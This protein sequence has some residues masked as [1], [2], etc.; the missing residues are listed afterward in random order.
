MNDVP[1][2]RS[3]TQTH[4]YKWALVGLLWFCGF[5]N[6][7]DR[8]AVFSVTRSLQSEFELSKAQL[9]MIGSSF[10]FVYALAAPFAGALVDRG[11]RRAW[12]IGG[13]AFWSLICALTATSQVYWHLLLFRALEGL[14]ETFYFPASMSLIAAFHAPNTR[15]K[16]MGMHQTSVYLGSA[17]GGSIAGVLGDWLGWRS[18][19]WLFG[20][21]GCLLVPMLWFGLRDPEE[22]KKGVVE[23]DDAIGPGPERIGLVGAVLEIVSRPAALGVLG[24]FA[25]ANFV[26]MVLLSWLPYFVSERFG[27]GQARAAFVATLFLQITS[28]FGAIMG[29][30]LGDWAAGKP[31]GRMRVQGA[32]LLLGAPCVF[33]AARAGS[34]ASFAVALIGIGLC[35]GVYDASIFAS[36]YDLVRPE[37]RGKAAGMMNTIGW[38]AGSTA[39]LLI[40]V[41]GD[42]QGLS[43]TIAATAFVYVLAGSIGLVASVLGRAAKPIGTGPG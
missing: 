35:K 5:F 8:Q 38:G 24:M 34:E 27:V 40:G 39:P 14:G 4:W 15:S 13:L 1:G 36:M 9:G 25:G 28:L 16:A 18:P 19:F 2:G 33:L 32:A 3:W 37:V 7:A 23:A 42:A 41:L 6:Y 21:V 31:G 22:A 30:F 17:L 20:G 43:P 29:G 12:I 10:M 11:S 26:A